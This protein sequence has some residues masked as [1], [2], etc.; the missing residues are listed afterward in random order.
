MNAII[1]MLLYINIFAMTM[2]RSCTSSKYITSTMNLELL[3]IHKMRNIIFEQKH[4]SDKLKKLQ[5]AK[6]ELCN[7][8]AIQDIKNELIQYTRNILLGTQ[9]HIV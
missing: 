2:M 8:N 7:Q 9:D 3:M 4:I 1:K 5:K 6:K